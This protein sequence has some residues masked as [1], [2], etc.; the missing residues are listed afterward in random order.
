M[1]VVCPVCGRVAPNDGDSD[2]E[3]LLGCGWVYHRERWYCSEMCKD[4]HDEICR[5]VDGLGR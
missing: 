2:E 3:A 4:I 5:Y 1:K